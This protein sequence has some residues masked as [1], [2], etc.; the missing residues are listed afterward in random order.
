MKAE[1]IMTPRPAVCTPEADLRSVAELMV[2]YDCGE[3][4]VV[5]NRESM[6]PIGVVTDRDITC[7]TVAQGRNPLDL[8]AA[9]CMSSPCVTVESHER[10]EECCRVLEDQQLRRALVVDRAGRLCGIIS[11]ATS[12]SLCI[13]SRPLRSCAKY[14][15][16]V[17][18]GRSARHSATERARE[19]P[20]PEF[21]SPI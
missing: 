11:Q 6:V 19:A 20:E 18:V 9:D 10:V 4:P 21:H 14:L 5:R 1:Q 17:S 7:R 15:S 2:A 16:T 8:T 13:Q 12:Q 3:I